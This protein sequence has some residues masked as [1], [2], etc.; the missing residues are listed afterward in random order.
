MPRR[1]TWAGLLAAL[2]AAGIQFQHTRATSSAP[3]ETAVDHVI[4]GDTVA[5]TDGRHVRYIGIDTPETRRRIGDRWIEDPQPFSR[6][7]KALNQ[8]LVEG[9]PVRLEYDVQPRD[10]YGRTLAYVYVDDLM[11]NEELL[12]QGYAKLLTIPPNVKYV[13][14][15]RAV[16]LEAREARRGVWK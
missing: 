10:K 5:L 1:I 15:F 4:D 9:Q 16:M 14:R 7:A 6:E 8:A 13:D 3:L 12:R 11:V 2:I